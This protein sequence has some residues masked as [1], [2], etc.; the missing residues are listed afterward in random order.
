MGNA[1]INVFG[2]YNQYNTFNNC[3]MSGNGN[4]QFFVNNSDALSLAQSSY[5]TISG[6]SFTGATTF[7]PGCNGHSGRR[8][9]HT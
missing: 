6:G 3:T 7:R 4:I 2:N 1:G 9:I 8:R 5:N